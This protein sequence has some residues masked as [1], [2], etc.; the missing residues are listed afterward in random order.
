MFSMREDGFEFDK[1]L[2]TMDPAFPRPEDGG[3]VPRARQN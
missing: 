3:P 1:F 2:L